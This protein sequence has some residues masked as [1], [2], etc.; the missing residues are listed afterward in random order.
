MNFC[1]E[2]KWECDHSKGIPVISTMI[3]IIQ[4][5]TIMQ[6]NTIWKNQ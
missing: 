5:L 1:L 3:S 6:F 4:Y 2:K